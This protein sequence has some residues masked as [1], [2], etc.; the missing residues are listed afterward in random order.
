[1]AELWGLLADEDRLRVFAALCLGA[2]SLAEIAERAAVEPYRAVRALKRLER[3]GLVTR[4]GNDFRLRRDVIAAQARATSTAP[5]PYSEDGLDPGP[6]VVLRA[7]L[8]AGRLTT[9]PANRP[10]DWSCSITSRRSSTW[11]CAIRNGR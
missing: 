9:I 2:E 5:K 3:G 11:V 4:D 1:M 8:R 10:S 7:F 6:A